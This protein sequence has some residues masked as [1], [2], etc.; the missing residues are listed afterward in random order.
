MARKL[1]S[2]EE[3]IELQ[4]NPYVQN[5][6]EKSIT[7]TP[8]FRELFNREYQMG[9][10]PKQIFRDAGFNPSVLGKDRIFSL[11]KRTKIMADRLEGFDDIRKNNPGR[12]STKDL[13][14]EEEINYLKHRIKYLEQENEFLKKMKFLDRKAKLLQDQKK[15]SKS[16][17]K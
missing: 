9:K 5:V 6:S 1:F 12:P 16:F 13:T 2:S 14:P 8:E 15:S 7:Y 11:K 10:L 4:A 3:I 17:R